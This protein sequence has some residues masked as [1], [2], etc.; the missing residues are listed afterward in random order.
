[1]TVDSHQYKQDQYL[2]WRLAYISVSLLLCLRDLGKLFLSPD[3]RTGFFL[4]S[5]F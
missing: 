3:N 2:L 1:M 4:F 5:F